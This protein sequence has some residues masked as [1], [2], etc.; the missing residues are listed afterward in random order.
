MSVA[1]QCRSGVLCL[2]YKGSDIYIQGNSRRATNDKFSTGHVKN[3]YH[4]NS[5]NGKLLDGSDY[6]NMAVNNN[7]YVNIS[8]TA[9]VITFK[10]DVGVQWNAN[11]ITVDS[12]EILK[13]SKSHDCLK[14][15]VKTEVD[16]IQNE[17]FVPEIT[18]S[19]FKRIVKEKLTKEVRVAKC[20]VSSLPNCAPNYGNC[21]NCHLDKKAMRLDYTDKLWSSEDCKCSPEI[22]KSGLSPGFVRQLIKQFDVYDNVEQQ[23][24]RRKSL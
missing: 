5:I 12:Y 15:S 11:D 4:G 16:D 20:Y 2:N 17:I 3:I 24:S 1:D 7:L 6:G 8:S 21:N 9:A 13:F 10:R 19:Q 18:G 14:K 22:K 23:C